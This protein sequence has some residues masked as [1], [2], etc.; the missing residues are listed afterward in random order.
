MGYGYSAAIGAAC[1][2]PDRKIVHVTGDGSFHMNLNEL[3]TSVSNQFPLQRCFST[4]TLWEW[5]TSGKRS[6]YQRTLLYTRPNRKTDY[7]KLAEAFGAKGMHC[8]TREELRNALEVAAN[9]QGPMVIECILSC[10]GE[11]FP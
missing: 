4:I 2:W 8:E 6:F 5:F 3:C 10:E 1:G 11:C 7:V 9:S